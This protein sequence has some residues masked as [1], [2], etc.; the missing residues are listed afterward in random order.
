MHAPSDGSQALS[1]TM[2]ILYWVLLFI[3]AFVKVQLAKLSILKG[4]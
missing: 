3:W 1:T 4:F 2:S